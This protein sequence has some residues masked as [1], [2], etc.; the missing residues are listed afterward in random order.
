M[1]ALGGVGDADAR[2]GGELDARTVAFKPEAI[3]ANE[4]FAVERAVDLEELRQSSG[5]FRAFHAANE[6]GL[7]TPFCPASAIISNTKRRL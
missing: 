4:V 6:D 7:G 2:G 5:A 3:G 1:V